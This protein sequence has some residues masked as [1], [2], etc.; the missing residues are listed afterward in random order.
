MGLLVTMFPLN[1]QPI[2]YS[3]W[4]FPVLLLLT[5]LMLAALDDKPAEKV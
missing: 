3:G 5:A 1:S 4:W 2:L